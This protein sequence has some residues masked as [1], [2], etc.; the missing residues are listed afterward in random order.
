[1]TGSL[2]SNVRAAAEERS[3]LQSDRMKHHSLRR[4]RRSL[5]SMLIIT[6]VILA[7]LW[8]LVSQYIAS[9]KADNLTVSDTTKAYE[10]KIDQYLSEH[11][12]ER[13]TF[14]LDYGRLTSFVRADF[15]E[16]KNISLAKQSF[17]RPTRM[18]VALRQPI[19][20]WTLGTAKYYIDSDGVA[21]REYIGLAPSLVVEDNT[22][23]DPAETGVVA[24][25]KTIRFI[26]RVVHLL[27]EAGYKVEKIELPPGTSREIDLRVEGRGYLVKTNLDRDPAGQVTDIVNAIKFLAERGLTPSYADVRVSSKLYYQ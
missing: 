12:F 18:T 11:A 2:S 3:T 20:S 13:F 9:V 21:F 16:V 6:A 10:G 4:K 15:P 24:S 14:S 25:E 23:I 17:L 27:S 7:G 22:G 5:F 26:G 8:G 19:A 1:M